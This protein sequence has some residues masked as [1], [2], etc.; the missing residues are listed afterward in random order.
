M[1]HAEI[2]VPDLILVGRFSSDP[3]WPV[4]GDRWGVARSNSAMLWGLLLEFSI[5]RKEL[6][7]DIVLLVRSLVVVIEAKSGSAG[8]DAKRQIEEYAMLLH[9]FHKA[10]S[11]S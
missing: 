8:S 7:I 2:N 11:D 9:Y 3:H 4:L 10:T 6:R 5:P 1:P